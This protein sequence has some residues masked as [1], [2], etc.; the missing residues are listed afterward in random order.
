[1]SFNT[2]K[3]I[4]VYYKA[5]RK[6]YDVN[7]K[8]I[9]YFGEDFVGSNEATE[10]RFYMPN[11]ED[12]GA[13]E[14][15]VDVKR[16]NG[17]KRYDLLT[18]VTAGGS[19]YYKLELND[20]YSSFVGKVTIAFKAYKGGIVVEDGVITS[21][22]APVYVS[23]IFHL[24]IAYAPNSTEAA[25]AF[26]PSD[27]TTFISALS[28]KLNVNNGIF[29]IASALPTL[30]GGVYNGQWFL[31]KNN[32]DGSL[33]KLFYI[34]GS[35]AEEVELGLETLKLTPTGNGDITTNTG[36]LT[37]QQPNGTAQLGLYNDVNIGLGED[38]FYYGKA[39]AT[40]TK[41]QAIQFG[42][43]QGDHILIKPAVSSEI[44]A[45]PKLIM[46]IA[47]HNIANNDF[48]YVLAFGKLDG[49][50]SGSFAVG[51][52]LWFNS[53]S[54]S[55]GLLTATQP[56]AP[57]AKILMCAVIKA[58]TSGPANNGVIQVRVNIEPKLGELQDVNITSV[59]NK[60]VLRY[61]SANAR[62]ENVADLTTAE[63]DI[64]NIEDG[65]TIVGKANA[66]KDNNEF[67]ATYLKKSSASSTY[68]PLSSKGVANGVVPL[69]S[70]GKISSSFLS[71]EQDDFIEFANLG[72]FPVVGESDIIYCAIDTGLIYRWTG[73]TYAVISPS[74]ALGTTSSTAFAGDRGL[75]TETKTDNIVDGDQTLSDTKITNSAI[76]VRPLTI[77]AITGTTANIQEWQLNGS[78]RMSLAPTGVLSIGNAS[79]LGVA[80]IQNR[81]TE[82]NAKI[83]LGS[84]GA[85]ITRNVN[86][87]NPSLIVNEQQGT[88]N[89]A[90]FQFGGANKL[91]VT[92]DGF[93]NQNGTR[94]FHQPVNTSNT[95][96]GNTSGT[97]TTT[98][99]A[100]NT[101]FGFG[102]LKT[103]T[104]GFYNTAVGF[105]TL[106]SITTGSRNAAIGFDT[107][108][109]LTT[110]TNNTFVG[111]DAG[112]NASQLATAT[113]S[114]GI[115]Y[116]A[117]TDASNQMVFGNASVTQFK[118]DRNASAVLLAPQTTITSA[119]FPP[120]L[121]TRTTTGTNV[122]VSSANFLSSTTDDMIDGF[123]GTNTFSIRD[124][125]NVINPIASIGALRS[126]ADNSGRMIFRTFTTGT[127]TEK[128]TIM[129]N[130]RVGIGTSNPLAVL[131]TVGDS[132]LVGSTFTNA[133]YPYSTNTLTIGQGGANIAYFNSQ[134]GIN[135]TTPTAQLQV[136]SG[137][138]TRVPLIVDTIASPTARLQEWRNNGTTMASITTV[139]YL[140]GPGI[141][142]R[143]S[144]NN[145]W[146]DTAT[147]GT[148][149]SRNVND[150]NPALIV[151]LTNSSATG[152][153]AVFSRAG[154][155]QLAISRTGVIRN[156]TSIDNASATLATTGTTIERNV[157]DSN[158]VLK[159]R[160]ANASASGRLQEW[161]NTSTTWAYTDSVGDFYNASGTY[162]TISDLRVKENIENARDY[163]EDIMKLRVV[164]YSLKDEKAT[165]PTHLGF[166]AQEFE[167]VFPKM[168]ATS[169]QGD[170]KDF[171]AIKTS[172]LIPMLVK[173]IQELKLEIEE[174]KKK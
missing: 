57:N 65:T 81:T 70:D 166:I 56:T 83:T 8:P 121:S 163:M 27:V 54:G 130:G 34:N 115:G 94:L 161:I 59:A 64:S 5:D 99:N 7:G 60:N 87:A 66:D 125:A 105:D 156:A 35:T 33:G 26:D 93:L 82:N 147:T 139:G 97:T 100:G 110:G 9:S 114:T 39:S 61:S 118:F 85:V 13:V 1:M 174:L 149:I 127:E 6:P 104:S 18:K 143:S 48:G 132:Y 77:N 63:T 124:S 46:G 51:S 38:V 50:D 91:E 126:G 67:D 28:A 160:Q 150:A 43:Y 148:N 103:I 31:V 134:V 79:V 58:E 95:F 32:A 20:W 29:V 162:G 71:G 55:N 137:A 140:V 117:Y 172:V 75:A 129:P 96:F 78:E 168:V 10:V 86:D 2:A 92:K 167:Q 21:V 102:T 145:A 112:S 3:I 170:I 111:T 41:G 171:K 16:A 14:C 142:E 12:L 25:P 144:I 128:M 155:A 119:T 152:N 169:E 49:Y 159:V 42:G 74:L 44:N 72:A 45:N 22:T 123:G 107:A 52:L 23:D 146:V 138:T 116:Q 141:Y 69:N 37:W 113:N 76:G 30:T 133:L 109:S 164:K 120:L 158:V 122:V 36:K 135:E 153:I 98:G 68:V 47:K 173:A 131:H 90:N 84:T 108:N 15:A 165:E 62:W 157:N 136:K 24:Q 101:G 151:D 53:A 106:R 17:D 88:G 80:N 19:T 73:S 40:I 11:N 4:N 154:T 89:I